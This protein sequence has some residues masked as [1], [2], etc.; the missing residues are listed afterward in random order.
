M[1]VRNLSLFKDF[2]LKLLNCSS[3]KNSFQETAHK[4]LFKLRKKNLQATKAVTLTTA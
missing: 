1:I 2:F 4:K 3:K